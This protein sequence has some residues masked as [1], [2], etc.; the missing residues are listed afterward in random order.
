MQRELTSGQPVEVWQFDSQSWAPA[1]IEYLHKARDYGFVYND[2]RASEVIKPGAFI[3]Y[4]ELTLDE[5]DLF[6]GVDEDE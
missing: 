2:G 5:Y 1:C 6:Y 4:K 3:R